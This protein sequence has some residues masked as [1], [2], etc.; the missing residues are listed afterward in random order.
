ME[1]YSAERKQQTVAALK[2]TKQ[3][4][5]G[6]QCSRKNHRWQPPRHHANQTCHN[7][8]SQHPCD[9]RA[10]T[11]GYR[12]VQFIRDTSSKKEEGPGNGTIP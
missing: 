11:F 7:G 10:K 1:K 5:I 9:G 12:D 3:F 8:K 4:Q 6:R 2:K